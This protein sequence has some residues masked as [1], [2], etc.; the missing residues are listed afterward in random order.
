MST[1]LEI[2]G[3]SVSRWFVTVGVV[4]LGLAVSRDAAAQ[5]GDV[6][7]RGFADVGTTSFTA[8]R[9]F[10]A[11]FGSGRAPVFGGGLELVLPQRI[12]IALR[13]SRV[14][15]T[16][17]RVFVFGD[18]QFDLG[19][20]VTVSIVP[21]QLTGTYRFDYGRR[22]VPYAGAGVAWHRYRESSAFAEANEDVEDVF[23]GYHALGGAEIRVAPWA[24]AAFEL[25]WATVPDALGTDPNSVARELH[26]SNLGGTT[27]RVRIAV[28]R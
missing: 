8:E 24:A 3:V 13:A 16:G 27:I 9:S 4:A 12:G 1:L 19:I 6:L 28:G 21:I 14:R 25:E 17:E 7:F 26:D 15:R 18:Q 22:F 11:V 5:T 10:E 20:P 23:R 2:L